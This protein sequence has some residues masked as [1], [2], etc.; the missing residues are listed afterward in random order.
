[1]TEATIYKLTNN[2]WRKVFPKLIEGVVNKGNK[3][4]VY[5]D[6]EKV[7]EID[8]L[9]WSFEQLSFLP[10]ATSEDPHLNEQPV[11]ISS[12]AKSVNGAKVLAITND[13]IPDNYSD[14]EKIL[15]VCDAT[16][17]Q[18]IPKLIQ[19]LESKKINCNYFIQ[20]I[21][22]AWDKAENLL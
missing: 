15:L 10:H 7:S 9:L 2:P 22:G 1:M 20:S 18:T 8:N 3:V 17:H 19:A 21:Q 5:C 16:Q 14:Y 11:I 13:I 12:N 6:T 4:H